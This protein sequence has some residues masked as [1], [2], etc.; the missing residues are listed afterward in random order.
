ML[1]RDPVYAER[2]SLDYEFIRR[3]R[4]AC[5]NTG[6]SL[7]A[8]CCY[9]FSKMNMQAYVFR[10]AFYIYAWA[11]LY[12]FSQIFFRGYSADIQLLH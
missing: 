4:L 10:K 6:G 9:A 12:Y 8:Y 7:S 2:N 1:A 3:I 11:V 5:V